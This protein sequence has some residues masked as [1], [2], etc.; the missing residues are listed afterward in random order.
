MFDYAIAPGAKAHPGLRYRLPFGRGSKTGILVSTQGVSDIP[1]NR[2]KTAVEC[3]DEMPVLSEHMMA[4]A[5][6]LSSYYLQPLG[7]VLFQCLPSYLRSAKSIKPTRVKFWHALPV[8]A[9][10]R[11]RLR[12]RSPRQYELLVAIGRAP[13]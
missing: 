13:E 4:L 2:I 12:K 3:L 8:E 11:E 5:A 9:E 1:P 10:L 6:W 7:E